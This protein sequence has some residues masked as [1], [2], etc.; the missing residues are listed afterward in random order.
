MYIKWRFQLITTQPGK[1][2]I[3]HHLIFLNRSNYSFF[4]NIGHKIKNWP[5]PIEYFA[6]RSPYISLLRSSNSFGVVKYRFF[7]L[8]WCYR[9]QSMP[10]IIMTFQKIKF[11]KHF[12]MRLTVYKNIIPPSFQNS[13]T[14]SSMYSFTSGVVAWKND[15]HTNENFSAKFD[16]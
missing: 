7:D 15:G 3:H 6:N 5:N 14:D 2:M 16:L 13:E 4:W 10:P 8:C 9:M 11:I 12:K 1:N